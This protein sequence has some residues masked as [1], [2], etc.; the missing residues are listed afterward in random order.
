MENFAPTRLESLAIYQTVIVS[1][2]LVLG[3]IF[4]KSKSAIFEIISQT[5]LTTSVIYL[6]PVLRNCFSEASRK[7]LTPKVYRAFFT[8]NLLYLQIAKNVF[9]IMIVTICE[10]QG[11]LIIDDNA[12]DGRPEAV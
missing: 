10:I 6:R 2:A 3:K 4:S 12:K 9:F 8:H 11:G 5:L 7:S 1:L